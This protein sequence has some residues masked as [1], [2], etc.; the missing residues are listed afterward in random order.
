[1]PEG[2]LHLCICLRTKSKHSVRVACRLCVDAWTVSR[3]MTDKWMLYSA[4]VLALGGV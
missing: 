4:E 1:M 3:K 2:V